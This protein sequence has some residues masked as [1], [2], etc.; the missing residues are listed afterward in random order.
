MHKVYL[1]EM[2][3]LDLMVEVPRIFEFFFSGLIILSIHYATTN[4]LDTVGLRVPIWKIIF[5]F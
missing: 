1:F 3:F 5:F 2:K 4:E